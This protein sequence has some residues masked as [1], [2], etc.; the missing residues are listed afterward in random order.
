M[1]NT[2]RNGGILLL[3]CHG[4]GF[5]FPGKGITYL[6]F[7]LIFFLTAHGGFGDTPPCRRNCKPPP[8]NSDSAY[9]FIEKQIAFG[10]RVPGH[11]GHQA[12]ADF[13][14]SKLKEY[15]AVTV[16]QSF[17]AEAYDGSTLQL[18]NIIGSFNPSASKRI[19]LATH[20]DTRP[21][22]D[23]DSILKNVPIPGAN[24][25]GSGTGILLEIA[26]LLGGNPLPA[27][28]IDMIFFDGEDHG[29]PEGHVMEKTIENAG[30]IWWCLGSQYWSKNMHDPNYHAKFGILLDMVGGRDARF[31]KEGG[32]MQ[33]AKKYVNKVWK[34]AHKIGHDGHF[35]KK[36]VRGIM[37]DHIFV[38]RDAGIPMIDIIEYNPATKN[39][40]P[41]Y[42]HTHEDNLSNI[43]KETLQ[44]VGETVLYILYNE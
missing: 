38:N 26:R 29:E 10:P 5:T 31:Y 23:K 1:R 16:I 21:F 27:I 39:F 8:F 3:T 15:G 19:L 18:K 22:A 30:K 37:D 44:A 12:C 20:W 13:I 34:A 40:F 43:S 32:S 42:H 4:K 2:I 6:C 11:P 36:N 7:L 24:D 14:E 41:D 33:F 28:G 9:H 35:I 17:R 25:G